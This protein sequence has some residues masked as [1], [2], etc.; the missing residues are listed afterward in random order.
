MIAKRGFDLLTPQEKDRVVT[1]LAH[2]Y[3]RWTLE[4]LRDGESV[5]T[6]EDVAIQL[7]E[8]E[9]ERTNLD[10]QPEDIELAV[11][12]AHLPKLDDTEAID[13]D[14]RSGQVRYRTCEP[15]EDCL[16]RLTGTS[17]L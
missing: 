1:V 10:S 9:Q 3:R 11:R 2:R 12:H 8:W 16:E 13:F 4:F 7:H 6:A 17:P 14:A 5:S 15:V